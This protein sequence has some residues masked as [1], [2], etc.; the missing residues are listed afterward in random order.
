MF[1]PSPPPNSYIETLT[2]SVIVLGGRTG[3]SLA[4]RWLE[5]GTFTAKDVDSIPGKKRPQKACF[6]PLWSKASM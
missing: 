5:L 1:V 3:S 4:V 2:P 6:L